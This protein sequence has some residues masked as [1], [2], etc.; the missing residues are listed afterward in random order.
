MEKTRVAVIGCGAVTELFHLP[1]LV[2]APSIDVTVLVDPQEARARSLAGRF[3][4]GR[5]AADYRA[6]G[7]GID[8]ALLAL[9]NHLHASVAI[10]LLEQGRHVLVEKPMARTPAECAAMLAAAD[11]AGR[12][13]SVALVKRFFPSSRF[14]RQAVDSGLL[15]ELRTIDW[16]EG[17]PYRW[18][19]ASDFPFRRDAAG[20]GVLIDVG[21]HV[22]DLLRW[23]LGEGTVTGYTDDAAGGVEAD[24]EARLRFGPVEA[25]IELSRTRTLRNSFI[26]TGSRATLEI[27]VDYDSSARLT[28]AGAGGAA[29]PGTIEVPRKGPVMAGGWAVHRAFSEQFERFAAALRGDPGATATGRD[30]AAVAALVDACYAVRRPLQKPWLSTPGLREA[31]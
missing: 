7:E 3:G 15:G 8:A 25:T 21:A 12:V 24:C 10:D 22:L 6:M 9:P 23:W 31:V 18:P 16:R 5:V 26:L 13:L 27:E 2:A 17:R 14:V 20:G 28:L 11:A 30:G 19:L 29:L 1:A 4:V